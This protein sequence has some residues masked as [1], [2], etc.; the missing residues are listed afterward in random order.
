[1]R[2]SYSTPSALSC[3]ISSPFARRVCSR[4]I[5]LGFSCTASTSESTVERVVVGARGRAPRPPRPDTARA[6]GA[7]RSR[8]A[9][10]RATR[11]SRP[12]PRAAHELD[13]VR[14]DAASGTAPR[15]GGAGAPSTASLSC[16]RFTSR[17]T[18]AV[19][20]AALSRCEHAEDQA[21]AH[22]EARA[23]RLGRARRP[24]AR[25]SSRL[26]GTKPR[27]GRFLGARACAACP[28]ARAGGSR[29][30]ARA[31]GTRRSRARR[32][33]CA[34]RA[35]RSAGTRAPRR[36][37]TFS[38]SNLQSLLKPR[39]GSARSRR[40]RA[41][42]CRRSRAAAPAARAARR[43]AGT[44][45]GGPRGGCRCRGARKRF[46][47][48]AVGGVEAEAARSPRRSR[49]ARSR[50]GEVRAGGALGQLARTRA[51]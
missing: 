22:L 46:T 24:A 2:S 11:T 49:R 26:Q 35:R 34:R 29:S 14:R 44:S 20:G 37:P 39:C 16:E 19:V 23:Q 41:C 48:R 5:G 50:V 32:S 18:R 10:R 42:R 51:A 27:G 8:S 7:A 15:R 1:M 38:P 9:A 40:R 4:R 33:P 28:S 31:P 17:I 21:V 47:S 13:H 12:P 45:A 30:R 6:C 25:R 36:M 3:A 43:A